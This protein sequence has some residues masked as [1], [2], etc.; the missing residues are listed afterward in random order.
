M[1]QVETLV[2]GRNRRDACKLAGVEPQVRPPNGQDPIAYVISASI[3]RRH[4]TT[5]QRTMAVAVI[6]LEPEKGGSTRF[7]SH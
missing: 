6:Y 3:H 2:D 4:T 7:S 5:G 1:R